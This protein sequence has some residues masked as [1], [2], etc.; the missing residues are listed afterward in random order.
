MIV[1]QD[2]SQDADDTGPIVVFGAGL[3]G[4]GIVRA[5]RRARPSLETVV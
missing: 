5:L 2:R 1:L 3:M 4:S